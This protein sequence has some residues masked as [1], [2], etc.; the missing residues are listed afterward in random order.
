MTATW[1]CRRRIGIGLN[2]A[3]L[4]GSLSFGGEGLSQPAFA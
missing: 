3:L 2:T 4:L 1:A